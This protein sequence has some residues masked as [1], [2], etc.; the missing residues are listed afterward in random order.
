MSATVS[1]VVV[2]D[3]PDIRMLLTMTLEMDGDIK[4]VGEAGDGREGVDMATRLQ[5]DVV[6]I[7]LAMPVMD[8]LEALP[9]IRRACP[10]TRVVV[11]SGFEASAMAERVLV[12]GADGYLQKGLPASEIL[13][14]VRRLTGLDGDGQGPVGL[15]SAPTGAPAAPPAPTRARAVPAVAA[16]DPTDAALVS[17]TAA[18]GLL[19]L[20][21]PPDG[22][23]Q[24]RYLNGTARSMLALDDGSALADALVGTCERRRAQLGPATTLRDQLLT[25]DGPLDVR[26]GLSDGG[27][28][29]SLSE[30]TG[31][32]EATRLRQALSTT[33]HEIRN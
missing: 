27:V 14:H 6:L 13:D 2:D 5:P 18:V 12:A 4:V 31:T 11:L 24:V 21:G 30:S 1:A 20:D 9:L 8:G 10:Q 28:V 15:A 22:R 25:P 29:V 23:L 26:I 32:Q 17:E 16:L 19:L 3:T 7:D 33:A